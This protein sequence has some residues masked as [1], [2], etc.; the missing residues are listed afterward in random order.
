MNRRELLA[1]FL[2]AGAAQLACRGSSR[3]PRLPD[4]ELAFT[5]ERIGHRIRDGVTA[6]PPPDAWEDAGV[7]IVGGGVAG[8]S[9]GWRLA[10]AGMTD[11]V[12]LE[13]DDAAGGTARSGRGKVGAYP[14]GAHYIT[15]PMASN[16]ALVALLD[17][18]G[19]VAGSDADG[20]P[21]IAEQYLCREP[22]ERLYYRGWWY[23]GLYLAAGAS[24]E[25]LRQ[26][27]A[28]DAEI[29]RWVGWRDAAGRRAFALPTAAG[30]TDSEVTELDRMSVAAWMDA[31]GFTS[32]RLRWYVDYACRDD[33]GAPM[34]EISA[35]AGLLYFAARVRRPTDDY[36]PVITWPE[37]NGRLVAQLAR[38]QRERVRTGWA[39]A[40]L[41]PTDRGVDVVALTDGG[42]TARG[43]HAE[44]VI[45]A[46]PQMLRPYLVRDEHDP[47]RN[48][49]REFRYTPWMVANLHIS[50]RLR[51][52]GFEQAWD[53]VLYD[54]PALG[55]VVSTHQRGL[56][57]GPTIL[58]YYYPLL[59]ADEKAGRARM[60]QAGRDE[61]AEVALS[62]LERAHPEL[63]RV[64]TRL[65]VAR[66]G[67]A[68]V[69]P[70]PGFRTGAARAAAARPHRGIHFAHTDLSGVA[71]FEEAYYHG[72]RAAEEV[73]AAR[74]R[75]VESML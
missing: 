57:Y 13:L 68:M 12:V 65:D 31:R 47:S 30:T 60:L 56:D 29:A 72:I 52:R 38:P 32:P 59:D 45:L 40:S 61:W 50:Q 10:R 25:D 21:V 70:A 20:Q 37:G 43:L 63:R 34:T 27:A 11:V 35:W 39:V 67:H 55:Y 3:R 19:I 2:G 58:T 54:S 73:L 42:R 7:V 6:E 16:R 53:N 64:T 62:D 74:D 15:A 14:W 48:G 75:P 17:E 23:Q 26:R 33:Y 69:R 51:Y 44:R 66:W 9:A 46:A 49:A 18:M 36:Q 28:F 4:G 5:P 24:P 41:R 1:A 22:E 8:M 71:L